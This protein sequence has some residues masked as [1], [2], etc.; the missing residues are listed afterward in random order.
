MV[1]PGEESTGWPRASYHLQE[2][3]GTGCIRY[4]SDTPY[5]HHRIHPRYITDTPQSHLDQGANRVV[6]GHQPS[7]GVKVMGLGVSRL[8]PG[9]VRNGSR[10][11]PGSYMW[12]IVV[13]S[14]VYL[15]YLG[16]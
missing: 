3:D 10:V 11:Y 14:G 8:N 12:C 1:Y 4:T 2:I 5:L 6:N 9:S 15:V 13:V 16:H 7:T